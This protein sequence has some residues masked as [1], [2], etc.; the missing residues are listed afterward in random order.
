MTDQP[1]FPPVPPD[2]PSPAV[3][4]PT[5][6]PSAPAAATPRTSG[7]A[8]VSLVTGIL[9]WFSVPLVW[10]VIPTPLCTIAAIACGHMARAEIRRDPAVAGDGFAVAGLV[11]GWAMV[12]STVL[13]VLAVMLFFGGLAAF[14]AWAGAHGHVN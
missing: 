5:M 6:T 12:A 3:P 13:A 1:T 7:L 2:S 9:A 11:L 14:L 4:A 10:M 8:V